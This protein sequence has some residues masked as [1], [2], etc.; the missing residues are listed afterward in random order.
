[1]EFMPRLAGYT[2]ENGARFGAGP[3]G[4]ERVLNSRGGLIT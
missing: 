4:Q 2:K 1:M 3:G